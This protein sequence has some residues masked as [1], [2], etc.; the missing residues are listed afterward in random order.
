MRRH[1]EV[2]EIPHH[3]F[4]EVSAAVSIVTIKY[5]KHTRRKHYPAF[6]QKL[7]VETDNK[8]QTPVESARTF[9]LNPAMIFIWRS[10]F[11]QRLS[12]VFE[13]AT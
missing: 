1:A 9:E 11:W 8:L 3:L 4:R 12:M 6:K 5:E 13:L 10:A 7:A 2:D